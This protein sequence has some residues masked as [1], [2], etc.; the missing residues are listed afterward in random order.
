MDNV[1]SIIGKAKWRMT[2]DQ[3][4]LFA[5]SRAER[6]FKACSEIISLQAE[7]TVINGKFK[8]ESAY[9]KRLQEL[10]STTMLNAILEFKP[11]VQ[12]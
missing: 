9:Q 6:V 11:W 4:R 1:T 5:E 2:D 12:S 7:V 3:K 10:G 8:D